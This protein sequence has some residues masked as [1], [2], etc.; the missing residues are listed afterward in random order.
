M[1]GNAGGIGMFVLM[2]GCLLAVPVGGLIL[3]IKKALTLR[4]LKAHRKTIHM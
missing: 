4:R 2:A 3:E 1:Q